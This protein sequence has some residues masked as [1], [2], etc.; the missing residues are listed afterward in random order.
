[1]YI[2]KDSLKDLFGDSDDEEEIAP[3]KKVGDITGL[4]GSDSSSDEKDD[5]GSKKGKAGKASRKKA[6]VNKR[7]R[8]SDEYDSEPDA[9]KTKEDDDFIDKE[10]D[11]AGILGEY[12]NELQVCFSYELVFFMMV[13]VEV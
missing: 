4:F 6:D 7:S 12:D 1:M 8:D 2:A 5:D 9:K 13:C 11:L 10:D 3:V